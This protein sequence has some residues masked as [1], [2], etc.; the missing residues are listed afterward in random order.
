MKLS[1]DQRT[2]LALRAV[3]ALHDDGTRLRGRELAP[4]LGTTTQYLPQVLRPLVQAGWID[5][6]PGPTGGYLLV[7][8]PHQESLLA[9]IELM[10]GPTTPAPCVLRGG[11]CGGADHCALH[12][13]WQAAREALLAELATTHIGPPP[14]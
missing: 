5:S 3:R 10:E 2:D 6:E 9:L 13:P 12:D 7:A 11:P 8:D 14:E 4:R 1:L